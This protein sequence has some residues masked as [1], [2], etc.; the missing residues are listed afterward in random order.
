M[1]DFSGTTLKFDISQL[2]DGINEAN[3]L[4]KTNNSYWQANAAAMGDWTNSAGGLA[5]RNKSLNSQLDLQADKIEKQAQIVEQYKNELGENS[6]ATQKQIQILNSYKAALSNTEN[7]IKKNAN[8]ILELNEAEKKEGATKKELKVQHEELTK[9]LKEQQKAASDTESK[10]NKLTNANGDHAEELA[11]LRKQ[12]IE[13]KQAIKDTTGELSEYNDETKTA[14]SETGKLNKAFKGMMGAA[15]VAAGAVTAV[16][17]AVAG[18]AG[19]MIALAEN[20]R[21]SRAMFAQLEN[22]AKLSGKSFDSMTDDLKDVVAVTGELD[23]AFEG[24]NMLSNIKGTDK[25]ISKIAEAFAGA[26]AKFAGLKFEGLAEGLQETLATGAAVGPFAELIERTGGDLEAFNARMAGATD[27]A[28]RTQIA[29]DF[30]AKSGLAEVATS[31]KENNKALTEARQAEIDLQ[32][33]TNELGNIAEPLAGKIK[34]MGASFI[35]SLIPSLKTTGE[36]FTNLIDGVAGSDKDLAYNLGVLVGTAARVISSWW[37]EAK[38]ALETMLTDIIPYMAGKLI[39]KIPSAIVDIGAA[40]YEQVPVIISSI[41]DGIAAGFASLSEEVENPL[42][43]T[44]LEGITGAFK[45]ISENSQLITDGIILITGAIAGFKIIQTVTTWISA[46]K[47]AFAAL[48]AV[49]AAN[50]IGVVIAAITALIA[51]FTLLYKNNEDFRKF[52]DDLWAKVKEFGDNLWNWATKDVPEF[53]KKVVDGL[54]NLPSDMKEKFDEGVQKAVD[55]GKD[56]YNKGKDALTQTIDGFLEKAGTIKESVKDIG[57]RMIEGV[58]EGISNAKEWIADK[59]A[60][61]FGADGFI[62]KGIKKLLGIKSPAREVKPI[63]EYFMKGFESGFSGEAE[64]TEKIVN[65]EFKKLAEIPTEAIK[66]VTGSTAN[67]LTGATTAT[68]STKTNNFSAYESELQKLDASILKITQDIAAM[69]EERLQAWRRGE[70]TSYFDTVLANASNKLDELKQKRAELLAPTTEPTF[71]DSLLS[72]FDGFDTQLQGVLAN[73]IS[74]VISGDTTALNNSLNSVGDFLA[75]GL[76]SFIS[77]KMPIFGGVVNSLISGVWQGLKSLF[78]RDN[79][80]EYKESLQTVKKAGADYASAT[81]EGYTDVIR[82][83]RASIKQELGKDIPEA[84]T[85][86]I[87]PN[88]EKGAQKVIN[89]TQ[90]NYS[91]KALTASEIYRNNNRAINMLTAGAR[92]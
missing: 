35:T 8:K 58:W 42:L 2:R 9:K 26:S 5:E 74:G 27:E 51:G 89:Y 12:L 45:W 55:F 1:G 48:N 37:E 44:A 36:A 69:N 68:T 21:E 57:K 6:E 20:T 65:D 76:S 53:V 86:L 46:A 50:P 31:F 47:G 29:M 59:I 85:K 4:I 92:A 66:N 67:V 49:M 54:K 7:E 88:A 24:M 32:I 80:T 15:K 81:I 71:I 60:G 52:V 3:T 91:P 73:A 34:G 70:D 75:N 14:E 79:K 62:I 84:M 17:G 19:G 72:S 39:A 18:A 40:L 30:L 16:A 61:I 83:S 87:L 13:Q 23:A 28:G 25:E 22:N 77:A 82:K 90:N 41:A 33:A 64:N 11:A 43:K 38:P 10:I 78:N 56:L 63:G